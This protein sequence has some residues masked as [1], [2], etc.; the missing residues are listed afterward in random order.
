MIDDD[1][2]RTIY[3]LSKTCHYCN[4]AF[5]VA[6]QDYKVLE[7]RLIT[8]GWQPINIS[9]GE[10]GIICLRCQ[11]SMRKIIRYEKE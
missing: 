9:G 1:L 4:A 11:Q 2:N 8:A 5:M 6:T 3:F 10:R 7:D